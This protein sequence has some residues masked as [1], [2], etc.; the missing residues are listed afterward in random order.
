ML[1]LLLCSTVLLAF[2]CYLI[3]SLN[4][5]DFQDGAYYVIVKNRKKVKK[6]QKKET[7]YKEKILETEGWQRL[8]P[9]LPRDYSGKIERIREVNTSL[10]SGNFKKVP[11]FP[12][13]GHAFLRKYSFLLDSDFFKNLSSDCDELYGEKHGKFMAKQTVSTMI[14]LFFLGI[15]FVF[16]LT[17]EL[18]ALG[19]EKKGG[20]FLCLGTALVLTLIYACVNDIKSRVRIRRETIRRQFPNVVSKLTLL[21]SSGMVMEQAWKETA[22]SQKSEIYQEMQQTSGD[23]EQLLTPE[24]A[25]GK[26][27]SCCHTKETTELAMAVLQNQAKG[28]QEI[29][30]VLRKMSKE[31]W[32]QRRHQV[33]REAEQAN[34]KLMIPIMLLFVSILA[35]IIVPIGLNFTIS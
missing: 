11:L 4:I 34:A 32:I 15:P 20:S 28:N 33:K 31:A 1:I 17:H 2:F 10:M 13:C 7:E 27:I 22:F 19:Q 30:S 29:V 6:F 16:L 21:L 23:L 25:Y 14:S 18:F 26:F 3:F 24:Q 5:T 35:M 12:L 8:L 9:F